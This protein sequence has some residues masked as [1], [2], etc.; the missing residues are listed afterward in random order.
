MVRDYSIARIFHSHN[1]TQ[2]HDDGPNDHQRERGI[3]LAL[4]PVVIGS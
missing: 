1:N 3:P 2:V 4:H